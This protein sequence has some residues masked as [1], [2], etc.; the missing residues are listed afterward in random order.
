MVN[1]KSTVVLCAQTV[2]FNMMNCDRRDSITMQEIYFEGIACN[3]CCNGERLI[4]HKVQMSHS[5]IDQ[6]QL[7]TSHDVYE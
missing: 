4:S 1:Y 6:K 7:R 2:E 3:R 5:V